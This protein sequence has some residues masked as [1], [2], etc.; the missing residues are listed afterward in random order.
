V[1]AAT[2]GLVRAARERGDRVFAVGTTSCRTLE[3]IADRIDES[4]DLHGDTDL[5]ITPGYRFRVVDAMITNFH[6]PRSTLL[7]MISAFAG[8][9]LV[10]SAYR[11]AV[12][13]RYRFFIFGDAMLIL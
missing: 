8:R 1:S 9:Q 7:L 11:E 6:L 12:R 5:Y 3:S 13:Q 2:L 10:L 4:E